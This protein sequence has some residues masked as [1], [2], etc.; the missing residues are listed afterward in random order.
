[1]LSEE[2]AQPGNVLLVA[3]SF[4]DCA[5]NSDVID[6]LTGFTEVWQSVQ[7]DDSPAEAIIQIAVDATTRA[8]L[9]AQ[10]S[11]ALANPELKYLVALDAKAAETVLRALPI[12]SV[13]RQLRVIVFDPSATVFDAIENGQIY[14]AIC[15]DMYRAGYRAVQRAS[16]YACARSE[17]LPKA[18]YG[19]EFVASEIIRKDNLAEFRRRTAPKARSVEKLVEWPSPKPFSG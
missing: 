3:T 5:E 10:F 1:L 11:T 14:C 13:A 8:I 2:Q 12:Q 6:R 9:P 4:S 17:C 16:H 19:K 7:R 18:G 15:N